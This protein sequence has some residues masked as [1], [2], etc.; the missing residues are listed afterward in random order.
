MSGKIVWRRD[1]EMDLA[2][3]LRELILQGMWKFLDD[4]STNGAD[5]MRSWS[6]HLENA[7][8]SELILA[9]EYED[10]AED[11]EDSTKAFLAA[12]ELIL[13]ISKYNE[14]NENNENNENT[15]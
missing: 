7:L 13:K 2:N 12:A 10:S 3:L 15:N 1:K 8:Y 4:L 9:T 6:R 11:T 14:Y 5:D